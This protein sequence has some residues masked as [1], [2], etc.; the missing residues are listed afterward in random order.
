MHRYKYIEALFPSSTPSAARYRKLVVNF[1][2]DDLRAAERSVDARMLGE[3]AAGR[4][5]LAAVA[6]GASP[7]ELVRANAG[8]PYGARVLAGV[9]AD[10][11]RVWESIVCAGEADVGYSW[12]KASIA[13]EANALAPWKARA[14]P[15]GGEEAEGFEFGPQSPPPPAK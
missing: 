11:T 4:A 14:L 15:I 13:I 6:S 2:I 10:S 9:Q 7:A 12:L 3:M 1:A 8:G 5:A